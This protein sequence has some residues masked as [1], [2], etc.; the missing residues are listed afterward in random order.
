VIQDGDYIATASESL[1]FL[2]DCDDH[3]ILMAAAI[4]AIENSHRLI[5]TRDT[6]TRNI[7]RDNERFRSQ[8]I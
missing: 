1:D 8:I 5:H 2:G 6:F 7:N 4:R 3:S